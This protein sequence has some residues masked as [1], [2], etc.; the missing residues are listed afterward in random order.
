MDLDKILTSAEDLLSIIGEQ[1]AV[2][3]TAELDPELKI[4]S[5]PLD[6]ATLTNLSEKY[7][8]PIDIFGHH[9]LGLEIEPDC[10]CTR[11]LPEVVPKTS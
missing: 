4:M 11:G 10:A 2:R 3:R 6:I 9:V 7:V 1:I 8:A 5:H